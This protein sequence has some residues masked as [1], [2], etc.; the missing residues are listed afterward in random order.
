ML[1]V[2]TGGGL[3]GV[4][5]SRPWSRNG[6]LY[7]WRFFHAAGDAWKAKQF[8]HRKAGKWIETGSVLKH[9]GGEN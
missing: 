8:Y 1:E 7:R 6:A 2:Q 9:R 5:F 3:V 4:K